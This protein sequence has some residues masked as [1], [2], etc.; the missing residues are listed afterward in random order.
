[1]LAG[2]WSQ[3]LKPCVAA[4]MNSGKKRAAGSTPLTAPK[5]SKIAMLEK[6]DERK[7]KAAEKAKEKGEVRA[8]RPCHR[9]ARLVPTARA[10][11]ARETFRARRRPRP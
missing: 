5:L 11:R 9:R 6:A 3:L 1:M 8:R 10:A 2:P 7:A 4:E